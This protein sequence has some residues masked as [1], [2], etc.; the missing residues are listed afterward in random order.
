MNVDAW[1]SRVSPRSEI[2][3]RDIAGLGTFD[4]YG[5]HRALWTLFDLPQREE[6]QGQPAPFLFRAETRDG[7]PVF[8][9]LSRQKPQDHPNTWHVEPKRY[10]PSIL[11]GDRLAFKLRANPV[12]SRSTEQGKRGKRHDVVMD[13]KHRM[14]WK[15]IPTNSRPT[16]ALL[17]HEAGSVWFEGKAQGLGCSL[18]A[19]ALRVDGYNTWRQPRGKGIELA[20]LDFEG[21]L[22][23][24]EPEKFIGAL[25]GG[26][27]PAKAFGCGL[28]LVRRLG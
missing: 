22:T 23:V 16:L 18:D 24:T 15:E 25:L 6:R 2:G 9:V 14:R 17:A 27:G 20:T 5:Q 10:A 3:W 4:P 19:E 13:A 7:L 12:V 1:L 28:L 11:A 26:I 21:V 8:Y